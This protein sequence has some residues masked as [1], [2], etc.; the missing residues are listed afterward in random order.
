LEITQAETE[1]K[2]AQTNYMNALYD[3]TVSKLDLKKAVGEDLTK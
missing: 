3:L 2:T 1:L